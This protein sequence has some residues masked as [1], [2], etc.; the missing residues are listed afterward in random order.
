MPWISYARNFEDVILRRALADVRLGFYLDVG[1]GDPITG[2][3]TKHFYDHG[4]RGINLERD[5]QF[6]QRLSTARPR[7]IN[8]RVAA[9]A[10]NEERSFWVI[11]GSG[12]STFREA[13]ALDHQK[14]L[15]FSSQP[16]TVAIR[17]LDEIVEEYGVDAIHFLKIDREGME[18]DALRGFSFQ[19]VR[20]WIVLVEATR[21]NSRESSHE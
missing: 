17:T 20:P 19:A 21:P 9:G 8:L 10:R 6:W 11:P 7:D 13:H 12:S 2:S 14:R 16:V 15:G 3:V 18:A 5:P 1:A 4:W